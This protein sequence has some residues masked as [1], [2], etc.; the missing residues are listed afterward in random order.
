MFFTGKQDKMKT[1]IPGAL[2]GLILQSW[3]QLEE[4]SAG[5]NSLFWKKMK[6]GTCSRTFF[7]E[8]KKN[9]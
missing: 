5:R 6:A 9:H 2:K 4:N 1:N 3:E 7:L 8:T